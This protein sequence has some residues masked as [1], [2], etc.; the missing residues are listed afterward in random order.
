MLT[1]ERHSEPHGRPHGPGGRGSRGRGGTA[2]RGGGPAR[3]LQRALW[4]VLHQGA[5]RR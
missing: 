2:P 4:R 3:R 1:R 5:K